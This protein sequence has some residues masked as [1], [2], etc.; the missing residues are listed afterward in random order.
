MSDDLRDRFLFDLISQRQ[1]QEWQR[2]HDLDTKASNTIGFV[3]II[4]GFLLGVR[5][6]GVGSM[7]TLWELITFS[8]GIAS[9][10]IALVYALLAFRVRKWQLVPNV[11]TVI[12][13][14]TSKP[15]SESIQRIGGEMSKVILELE[16]GNNTKAVYVQSA[17]IF[18][19]FGIF[20]VFIY[21]IVSTLT[22]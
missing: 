2:V 10:I 1:S 11:K 15:L 12:E 7:L 20:M 21:T 22:G 6:L 4:V 18:T 8:I 9:L 3:S 19:L 14:Y 16:K 5:S 13:E 17:W